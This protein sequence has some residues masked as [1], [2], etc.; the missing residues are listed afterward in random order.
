MNWVNSTVKQIEKKK[1]RITPSRNL[2]ISQKDYLKD[3]LTSLEG[4]I[5]SG[6]FS[7]I[8]PNNQIHI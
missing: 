4:T 2:R 3:A 8:L 5:M 7:P 6:T 1:G